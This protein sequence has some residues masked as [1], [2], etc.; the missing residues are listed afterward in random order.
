[1][2]GSQ[3][4]KVILGIDPGTTI[5]GY[6]IISIKGSKLSMLSVG[7]LKL[8]KFDDHPLRLKMIF[9]KTLSLINWNRLAPSRL[10]GKVF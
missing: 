6:G 4:E 5:M 1:M 7:I 10:G 3:S 8:S 9:E 2:H